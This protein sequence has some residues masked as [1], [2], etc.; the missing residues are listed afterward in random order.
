MAE[1]ES[2]R[3]TRVFDAP[4][5]LVFRA[6]TDAEQMKRWRCPK[7]TG[8]W[9]SRLIRASANA[10]NPQRWPHQGRVDHVQGRQEDGYCDVGPEAQ[11]S[12]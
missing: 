2:L 11:E 8:A 12:V 9:K 3:L 6:W 1:G 10:A 4:R 5:P 7:S